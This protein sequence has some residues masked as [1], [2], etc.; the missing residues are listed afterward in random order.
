MAPAQ[1]R[2][3]A[4]NL[5]VRGRLRLVVE[6]EFIPFDGGFQVLAERAALAQARVQAG[7]EEADVAAALRLCAIEGR[8][9][10]GENRFDIAMVRIKR[11]ANADT[12]ANL[13]AVDIERRGDRAAQPLGEFPTRGRATTSRR[14]CR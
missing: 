12:D 6:Q 1:E 9:G 14:R 2:L 8:I 13:P 5:A 11:G 3:E 7:I 4:E 10:V